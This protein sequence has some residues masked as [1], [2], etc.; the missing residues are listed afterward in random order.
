[1]A[2]TKRTVIESGFKV[3][4]DEAASFRLEELDPYRRLSGL[5]LKEMDIGWWDGA[6]SRLVLLELKGATVWDAF[7]SSRQPAHD[8][9]IA[10]LRS[11][12]TDVLLILAAM[13]TGTNLGNEF[14]TLLPPGAR[15]YPGDGRIKLVF[16]VDTPA[17]RRPLLTAVKDELNRKAAGRAR[18]LGVQHLT[19]VDYDV[20]LKMGLPVGRT[21]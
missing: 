6:A 8:H 21:P 13:W 11:K 2:R 3:A 20:A 4:V 14:K 19:V 16:L 15:S 18:L 7:D 1:M 17:S 12:A 9:L 10:N 5:H